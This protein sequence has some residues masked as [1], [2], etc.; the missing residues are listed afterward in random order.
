MDPARTDNIDNAQFS[1]ETNMASDKDKGTD[2]L[3]DFDL[4]SDSLPDIEDDLLDD[5]S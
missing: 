5:D 2:I 4:D 3:D 1:Q